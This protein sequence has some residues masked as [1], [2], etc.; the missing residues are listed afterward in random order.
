MVEGENHSLQESP[1]NFILIIASL[2]IKSCGITDPG[3]IGGVQDKVENS[4]M[5]L[6]IT[7]IRWNLP[8][9]T[10]QSEIVQLLEI[11][12]EVIFMKG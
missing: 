3:S 1:R 4:G 7:N 9:P 2:P 8:D 10:V 11:T 12:D 5:F 6:Y